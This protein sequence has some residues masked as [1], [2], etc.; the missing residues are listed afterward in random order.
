MHA[1]IEK[2]NTIL[3][4]TRLL[5]FDFMQMMVA[6]HEQ[7]DNAPVMIGTVMMAKNFGAESI[8]MIVWQQL[9]QSDRHKNS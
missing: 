6:K 8:I 3:V 5:N 1:Y 4:R 7:N 9:L 2:K